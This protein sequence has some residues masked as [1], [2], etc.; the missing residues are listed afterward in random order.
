MA[1]MD[2]ADAHG[3][4]RGRESVLGKETQ[5]KPPAPRHLSAVP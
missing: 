2:G 5:P 1:L 4:E 3:Y